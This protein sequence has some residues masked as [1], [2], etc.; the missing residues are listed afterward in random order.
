V[1]DLISAISSNLGTRR[2]CNISKF[3]NAPSYLMPSLRI[4]PLQFQAERHITKTGV[5]GLSIRKDP[6]ILAFLVSTLY[7]H[8]TYRQMNREMDIM[9]SAMSSNLQSWR[10]EKRKQS[11]KQENFTHQL[12]L[13]V[14]DLD[15]RSE[16]LHRS[17]PPLQFPSCVH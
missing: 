5:L 16:S 10:S 13:D 1:C 14:Q 11:E 4:N 2:S 15:C 12:P 3:L 8:V 9:T 7:Q 6:V 17:V